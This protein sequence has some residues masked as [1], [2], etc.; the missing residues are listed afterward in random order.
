MAEDLCACT[1]YRVDWSSSFQQA[2]TKYIQD[3]PDKD[4]DKSFVS[5]CQKRGTVVSVP[6]SLDVEIKAIR[7]AYSQR[8]KTKQK[9][10]N[11]L[12]LVVTALRDYG[13]I[14][15]TFSKSLPRERVVLNLDSNASQ[16]QPILYMLQQYGGPST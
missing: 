4:R 3:L 6:D 1:Y 15:N 12:E 13:G 11:V 7:A 16:R 2:I 9:V 5:I 10:V 8:S 14:I